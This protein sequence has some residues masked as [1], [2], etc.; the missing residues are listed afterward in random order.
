MRC[1]LATRSLPSSLAIVIVTLSALPV[2]ARAE[3]FSIGARA[4]TT[5]I[6]PELAFGV[7][8]HLDVRIPLGIGS[9]ADVYDKTGIR[10]D[11]KLE[12]R[13]ALLLADFHPGGGAFRVSAGGGWDDNRLKVSAPVSELVRRYRPDLVPFISGGIGTI[14]GEA[15]GSSFAPYLGLGWGSAARS[16]RWGLSF[17]V[18]VIYQG[19]PHVDLTTD[20]NVVSPLPGIVRTALDAAT[21]DEEQRLERELEDYEYYPVVALGI[22]FRP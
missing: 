12:L 14:H 5:G 8:P 11:A 22:V 16:S 7:G 17:D 3:G 20:L 6:G 13:N 2:A 18:G 10:Y 19:S 4:G 15:T 9:Y 1:P 21:A